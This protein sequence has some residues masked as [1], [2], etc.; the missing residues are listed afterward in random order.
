[1]ISKSYIKTIQRLEIFSTYV[2]MAH[3]LKIN[4]KHIVVASV[5]GMVL[6]LHVLGVGSFG[7]LHGVSPFFVSRSGSQ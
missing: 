7:I 4:L 3:S 2:K 6:V 5:A 1:M